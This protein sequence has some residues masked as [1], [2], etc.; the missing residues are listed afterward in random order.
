MSTFSGGV[1]WD[2][3]E[4]LVVRVI[5]YVSD[6]TVSARQCLVSLQHSLWLCLEF[7]LLS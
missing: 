4:L 7:V 6:F 5:A 2:D 1:G 3:T